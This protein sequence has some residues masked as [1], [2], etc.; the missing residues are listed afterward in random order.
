MNK[1][2]WGPNNG[3]VIIWA[4]I[5]VIQCGIN[6]GGGVGGRGEQHCGSLVVV[7]IVEKWCHLKLSFSQAQA[8]PNGLCAA[9]QYINT[10]EMSTSCS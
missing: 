10:H 9:T 1:H 4:C 5:P 3:L 8:R 7:G 2:T 6:E